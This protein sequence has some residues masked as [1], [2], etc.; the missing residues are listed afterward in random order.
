MG[1]LLLVM[2]PEAA[3]LGLTGLE[4]VAAVEEAAAL[5]AAAEELLSVDEVIAIA[6]EIYGRKFGPS[7]ATFVRALFKRGARDQHHVFIRELFDLF[8]ALNINPDD[9]VVKIPRRLHIKL[10]ID[11]WNKVLL[12][13]VTIEFHFGDLN[14]RRVR[15]FVW[16]MMKKWGIAHYKPRKYFPVPSKK[17]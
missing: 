12:T 16:E 1:A 2:A 10:H 13:F 8:L 3:I 15:L 11:G 4:G 9:Y 7:S 6:N 5:V 14:E 17:K